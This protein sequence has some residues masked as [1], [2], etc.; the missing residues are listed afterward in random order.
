MR[1]PRVRTAA[2]EEKGTPAVMLS[3]EETDDG[4]NLAGE[5]CSIDAKGQ[6][7]KKSQRRCVG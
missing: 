5:Y 4:T 7:V 2:V 1:A 6:R 3:G